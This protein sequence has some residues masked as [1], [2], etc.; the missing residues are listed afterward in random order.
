[1]AEMSFGLKFTA[2]T[3]AAIGALGGVE[4]TLTKLG[5]VTSDLTSKQKE[6]SRAIATA[7]LSAKSLSALN[8]DYEKI[9]RTIEKIQAKQIKLNKL[10]NKRTELKGQRD[11]LKSE[12]LGTFAMGA[13]FM[14]PVKLA[15][16]Y[17]SAMA[18]VKKVVDFKTPEGFQKLSNEILALTRTL[19][20]ASEELAQIAASGGQLGVAEEDIKS[21][22]ET[23]AKMGVAFDMSA[24]DAGDSMA[25]LANVYNIPITELSKLGDAINELSNTSPAKA[26]D[27]IN[28]LSRVGGLAKQFGLTEFAAAS[29]SNTFIAMG[30][31][32]EVAGTAINSM[33]TKLMTAEQGGKAFQGALKKIGVNAKQLGVD[34]K[35]DAEGALV[36]FLEKINKLPKE[37]QMGVLVDLF[38]MQFADDVALLSGNIDQYKKS[39]EQLKTTGSDGKLNFVGSMENEFQA[40]AA[41]TQNSWQLLKNS[42]KELGITVGSV[43]LPKLN[44]LVGKITPVVTATID[45]AKKNPELIS[46]LMKL[47]G[48]LVS[49][50]VASLGLRFGF[51]FL[52][53]TINDVRIAT[54]IFRAQWLITKASM[55]STSFA[56][57]GAQ[58][59]G[60]GVSMKATGVA[61]LTSPI[62]WVV[63]GIALAALL[64]YKFWKPISA[65]FKGVWEGLKI[66]LEPLMPLFDLLGQAFA[67]IWEFAKPII[68]PIINFF[69]KLFSL[70]QVA[71]GGAQDVGTAIGM[72][73]GDAIMWVVNLIGSA[74][75]KVVGF[76]VN[77]WNQIKIAISGGF[78]GIGA[79]IVNWSPIGLFY[80]A[81]A[82]V[83][84]WFGIE[85]PSKFAGFGKMIIDGLLKGL[86]A[87]FEALKKWWGG[88]SGFVSSIFTSKNEIKSPSRLFMRHG[89]H[90]MDGLAIGLKKNAP[91]AERQMLS[92]SDRLSLDPKGMSPSVQGGGM[93][94][95]GG[96]VT[97]HFSPTINAAGGDPKQI[98]GLL[99]LSLR[100]LEM[101]LKQL[102]FDQKR[103]SY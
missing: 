75:D 73:I 85:L 55:V 102:D 87:K 14:L 69:S 88:V 78:V 3:S 37:K 92:L 12:L 34:I 36:S 77:I 46:K 16:D 52:K 95:S 89:G 7:P 70:E 19:P 6:L 50:K 90:I 100:E 25:K 8:K 63:A 35:K 67:K 21:F 80:S 11:A 51:N 98:E 65:F 43:V 1:M 72:M 82:K 42:L 15:I 62:T 49:V 93:G 61:F 39:I 54:T 18:D 22:T 74:W 56:G 60:L 97:I 32:P 45:W 76:F 47:A 38:G 27:I 40:R 5:R 4:K 59:A 79:L 41:T 103:R 83:M 68:E 84:S 33:L 96:G 99:K 28:A 57:L 94:G 48:I 66:G 13:T 81:F 17:E 10:L 91:K 71:E 23:I 101:M 29:L 9:G 2:T 64:I 30:K 20:M 58:I 31:T 86:K 26:S 53:G 44:E 24:G